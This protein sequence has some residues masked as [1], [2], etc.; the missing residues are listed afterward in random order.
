M[1]EEPNVRRGMITGAIGSVIGWTGSQI[2]SEGTI[3][4]LDE[5]AKKDIEI[6]RQEGIKE[7]IIQGGK[8][9]QETLKD[10]V[11]N[12]YNQGYEKGKLEAREVEAPPSYPTPTLPEYNPPFQETRQAVELKGFDVSY[13][14]NVETLKEDLLRDL[15]R[16]NGLIE[17]RQDDPNV[18]PDISHLQWIRDVGDWYGAFQPPTLLQM[19]RLLEDNIREDW[20]KV[21]AI[22]P[23]QKDQPIAQIYSTYNII[24]GS[25]H[26]GDSH[27]EFCQR[28]FSGIETYTDKPPLSN[29]NMLVTLAYEYAN[30]LCTTSNLIM[31]K[32]SGFFKEN[33]PQDNDELRALVNKFAAHR[34]D[35]GNPQSKEQNIFQYMVH[36]SIAALAGDPNGIVKGLDHNESIPQYKNF[37]AAL[38]GDVRAQHQLDLQLTYNVKY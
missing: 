38:N 18:N 21:G 15:E 6:A 24:D 14:I 1:A 32:N 23:D 19:M 13:K 3:S 5:K 22:D 17:Q 35:K 28:W 16:L 8:A 11:V 25:Q 30:R 33:P 26:L 7:G 27:I 20:V 37:V 9:A 2:R 36:R 10:Q 34:K 12:A 29:L 4:A 31:L